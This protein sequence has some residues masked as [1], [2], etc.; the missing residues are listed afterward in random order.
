[1]AISIGPDFGSLSKFVAIKSWVKNIIIIRTKLI[2]RIKAAADVKILILRP[3][4][5]ATNLDMDIGIASVDIVSN[6]E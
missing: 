2:E 3:L 5:S 4:A 6:K 1:M